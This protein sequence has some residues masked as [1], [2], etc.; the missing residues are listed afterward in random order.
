MSAMKVSEMIG[1]KIRVV[2]HKDLDLKDGFQ[3]RLIIIDLSSGVKVSLQQ[4]M[5][6]FSGAERTGRIAIWGRDQNTESLQRQIDIASEA[7]LD[8]KITRLFI[9]YRWNDS[10]GV[11]LEN[12]YVLHDGFSE[13]DNGILFYKPDEQTLKA[14]RFLD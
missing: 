11:M 13:H 7:N 2:F 5:A 14:F 8:S 12:G 9:P 3:E 4:E 10:L 1:E 6:I